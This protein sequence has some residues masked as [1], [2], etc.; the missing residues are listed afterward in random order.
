MGLSSVCIMFPWLVGMKRLS[1]LLVLLMFPV[2]LVIGP[3]HVGAQPPPEQHHVSVPTT[4]THNA[5][6]EHGSEGWEGSAEGKAYSE[7][8]HHLAGFFDTLLGLAELGNALQYP[9]PLWTRLVLPAA[10]GTMGVYL[11]I[12]SD[13]DAWP[14]GTLSFVESFFGEDREIVEHKFYGLLALL[15]AVVEALRR[16]GRLH[17]PAWAA[18]LVFSTLIAG[19]L[20]FV[21][22]HGDHPGTA[23]IEFHHAVLGTVSMAAA[24]SKGMA[25]WFPGASPRMVKRW[26]V[27]WAASVILFGLLLL[28]YSE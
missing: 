16:T 6:G 1:L 3:S 4:T 15:M 17:H 18:P 22:S 24:L 28:A 8:N 12:W 27:A 9:L 5:H 14:I 20:L 26:E 7:F 10:L 2:A 13:H 21:H 19:L 23:K 25:S 11:F